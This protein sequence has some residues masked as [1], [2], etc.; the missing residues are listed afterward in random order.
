MSTLKTTLGWIAGIAYFGIGLIQ[1]AAVIGGIS[2]WFHTPW[3]VSAVFSLLVAWTPLLG[4][5]AGIKGAMVSWGWGQ[6]PSITFFCWPFL[7]YAAVVVVA[8][9]SDSSNR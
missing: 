1:W 7:L 3:I 5:I 9:C 8:R 6:W 4:T 2:H